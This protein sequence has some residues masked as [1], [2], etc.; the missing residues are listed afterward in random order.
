MDREIRVFVMGRVNTPGPITAKLSEGMTL[1]QAIAGAGGV[2]EGGKQTAIT[3]TRK[4]GGGQ[5]QK[6]KVNLKDILKGKKKDIKLQE[7]DVIF[8]PES[9]W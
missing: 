3:I 9:F 8:V 5:E 2:A 7:G 4:N 6:I 1:L